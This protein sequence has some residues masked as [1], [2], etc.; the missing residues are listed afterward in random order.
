MVLLRGLTWDHPRGRAGLEATAEAYHKTH[1]G[2]E[3]RW[4]TRTLH[5]FGDQPLDRVAGKYDMLIVDHPFAGFIAKTGCMVPLDEQ[6]PKEFLD[7]QA[8]HSVGPSF[9]SYTFANHQWAL[10]VD[11]AAQ[12]SAYRP[13]LMGSPPQTW[14]EVLRLAEDGPRGRVATPLLPVDA[15]SSFLTLCANLGSPVFMGPRA[16]DGGAGKEALRI[17]RS[18]ATRGHPDSLHLNPPQTLEMMARSDAAV[19]SP[20]LYGYSNYSRAGF[21]DHVLKFA[22]ILSSGA[23]PRGSNLGGAGLA[24][25]STSRNVEECVKYAM[26]VAD[27]ETQRGVYFEAGGQPGH[28]GAWE[29]PSVNAA[30][31]GFFSDTLQ[32]MDEAYLRPRY[33]GYEVLQIEAGELI[34]SFLS[35]A[36]DA[37]GTLDRLD[38]L[39]QEHR[40]ARPS[41]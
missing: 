41:D 8:R 39:Y 21:R 22:N 13:D 15:I 40:R 36:K 3:V 26:Y 27:A 19:Y 24:I 11:A 12:V 35:E 9:R 14:A 2:V 16:V 32:T 34:H 33:D 23:G 31:N 29:D 1:P 37:T 30:S 7:E 4:E 5:E 10:A 6:M 20:L 18:L 25:S 28:R 17:L 38:A